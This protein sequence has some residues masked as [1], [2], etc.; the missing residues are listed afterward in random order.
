MIVDVSV[1]T[2]SIS[3]NT[4]NHGGG[5][6]MLGDYNT[7][8]SGTLTLLPQLVGANSLGSSSAYFNQ[9]ALIK[10]I[11][12][13]SD[14]TTALTAADTA[15]LP[16]YCQVG[17]TFSIMSTTAGVTLPED[18]VLHSLTNTN[19]ILR[20]NPLTGSLF[21]V[22]SGRLLVLKNISVSGSGGTAVSAPMITVNA[23]RLDLIEDCV[24]KNHTNSGV[25]GLIS[26]GG[27][28]AVLNIGAATLKN[29]SAMSGG[30]IFIGMGTCNIKS[31]TSYIGVNGEPNSAS[32]KGGGIYNQGT[33]NITNGTIAY[34]QGI[35]G[36]GIYS[37]YPGSITMS[38]SSAIKNN[39]SYN[40]GG[41]YLDGSNLTISGGSIDNNI[42]NFSAANGY[43]GGI[44]ADNTSGYTPE[45]TLNS[46]TI[47]GNISNATD[48]GGGGIYLVYGTLIMPTG[49]T[50]QISKNTAL[51]DGGGVFV[52][53]GTLR[54]Y[55]G[56]IGGVTEPDG[57]NSKKNGGGIC[58]KG[59]DGIEIGGVIIQNNR[60]DPGTGGYG[61]GIYTETSKVNF[62][63]GSVLAN[64]ITNNTADVDGGGLYHFDGPSNGIMF[65]TGTVAAPVGMSLMTGTQLG[66]F[67]TFFSGNIATV[68]SNE[69]HNITP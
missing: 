49:S 52:Y 4:A 44:Y 69:Q 47:S 32:Q 65:D 41:V 28:G 46:G 5:G 15:N 61:G 31:L 1:P 63:F 48:Q 64:S 25:G 11:G 55:G 43:G 35:W 21:T 8:N 50:G 3:G 40:G 36:G 23:G 56:K 66:T 18:M 10:S 38:G 19:T 16:L 33:V 27:V 37:E 68:G 26:V 24:L 14:L 59:S 60:T 17:S 9:Y 6:I 62:F 20:G 13:E 29:G 22:P 30:A 2:G 12:S 53:N 45:I 58:S 51:C 57:N 39:T 42:A 34:N 67:N 54:L 7:F